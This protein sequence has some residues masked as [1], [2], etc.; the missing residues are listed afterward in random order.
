MKRREALWSI[1]AKKDLK[2]KKIVEEENLREDVLRTS[3]VL[4]AMAFFDYLQF[5]LNCCIHTVI[6]F[7]NSNGLIARI[8]QSE[9]L[10]N[11][12]ELV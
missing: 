10:K 1:V 9:N 2:R 4:Y 6:I 3:S 5:F 8:E 11:R 7:L 12:T